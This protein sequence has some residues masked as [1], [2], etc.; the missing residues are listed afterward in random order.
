M[1]VGNATNF[2]VLHSELS[3]TLLTDYLSRLIE[4]ERKGASGSCIV[5]TKS[6]ITDSFNSATSFDPVADMKKRIPRE[7]WDSFIDQLMSC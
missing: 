5:S 4:K 1:C 7:L 3:P 6:I 2:R